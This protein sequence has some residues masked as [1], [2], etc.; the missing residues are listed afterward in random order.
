MGHGGCNGGA[1]G[2]GAR[3]V[4]PTEM[5]DVIATTMTKLAEQMHETMWQ[6]L[7]EAQASFEVLVGDQARQE[8]QPGKERAPR[9]GRRGAKATIG[10]KPLDN[11]YQD[12]RLHDNRYGDGWGDCTP[13]VASAQEAELETSIAGNIPPGGF[14]RRISADD[15]DFSNNFVGFRV[16]GG[17]DGHSGVDAQAPLA[18]PDLHVRLGGDIQAG[19]EPK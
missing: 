13:G 1:D 18:S 4:R 17:Q 14:I 2:I 7:Q 11:Q 10:D 5:E 16:G 6:A 3:D 19:P 8:G 12:F 15:L 9:R